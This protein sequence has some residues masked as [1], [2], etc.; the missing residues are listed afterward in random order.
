MLGRVMGSC[1]T[2][3]K[4]QYHRLIWPISSVLSFT[5]W[6]L[7]FPTTQA[8]LPSTACCCLRHS[9]PHVYL[10]PPC[11]CL[12]LACSFIGC[13]ISMRI[14][15]SSYL[16]PTSTSEQDAAQV[17]LLSQHRL[18]FARLFE[19]ASPAGPSS[20]TISSRSRSSASSSYA[21]LQQSLRELRDS[22]DDGLLKQ[23]MHLSVNGSYEKWLQTDPGT[24][25][26]AAAGST[27]ATGPQQHLREA[28]AQQVEDSGTLAGT[29]GSSEQQDQLQQQQ[30]GGQA[31][32]A[33]VDKALL[34]MKTEV[35]D[36]YAEALCSKS[37]ALM[38]PY[39]RVTMM[40]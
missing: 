40:T 13:E 37:A 10:L 28:V 2:C 21:A 39:A 11:L 15:S 12:L 9:W 23:R 8:R 29:N 35:L 24:R 14:S 22:M 5:W 32:L 4:F 38:P 6:P 27:G 16:L 33:A 31:L 3:G 30:Q 19:A 1:C 25:A 17:P 26:T 34:S 36:R 7:L 20:S 18:R